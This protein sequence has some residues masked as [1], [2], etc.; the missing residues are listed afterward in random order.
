LHLHSHT[1]KRFYSLDVLRG[2]AALSIVFYHWG[3]FFYTGRI[4]GPDGLAGLPLSTIFLPFYVNGWLAVDLFFCLSGFIFYWLYA[5]RVSNATISFRRFVWLRFSRLYPLHFLTLICVAIGQT[6][7]L[8]TRGD[9]FVYCCNDAWHFLLNLFFVSSWGFDAGPSFNGPSWSISVEVFL[10]VLFFALCRL[11]PRRICLLLTYALAGF[12]LARL[13]SWT[14]G[15]GICSFF[16]G[17]AVFFLYAKTAASSR[18]AVI[19]KLSLPLS[20]GAWL[21]TFMAGFY[22]HGVDFSALPWS[23]IPLVTRLEPAI[24]AKIVK[25]ILEMWIVLALFPATIFT[26]ATVE[27]WQGAL[28]RHFSFIGDI[29]YSS[30]LIHFPLQ[31]ILYIMDEQFGRQ[32][33]G[34]DYSSPLFMASFFAGLIFISLCSYRYFE[35]PTQRFLRRLWR[36]S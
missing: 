20:V 33:L 9:S 34:L 28:G 12:L 16:L 14:V 10:Y 18:L 6:W 4:P 36:Q 8:R 31:L 29:S 35:L 1:I 27:A 24:M 15:R 11:W 22:L 26:L 5:K 2:L 21:G 7:L 25:R 30:Y 17:G 13:C 3:H 19:A 32:W 23:H